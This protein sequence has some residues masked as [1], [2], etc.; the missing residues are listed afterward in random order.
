MIKKLLLLKTYGDRNHR[1]H[2]VFCIAFHA[3]KVWEATTPCITGSAPVPGRGSVG[4]NRS[5]FHKSPMPPP[6][7]RSGVI[8]TFL[9]QFLH[10]GAHSAQNWHSCW[11]KNYC[12][13]TLVIEIMGAILHCM[14]R[15]QTLGYNCSPPPHPPP[16]PCRLSGG[17]KLKRFH[18]SPMTFQHFLAHK[19]NASFIRLD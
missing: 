1:N 13:W 7:W 4:P 2:F 11:E 18:K 16:M 8:L 10:F 12:S 6:A 9:C 17:R 19:W 3:L 5:F 14:P 15:P